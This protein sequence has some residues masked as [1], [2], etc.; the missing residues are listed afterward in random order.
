MSELEVSGKTS[1]GL[2]HTGEADDTHT[3]GDRNSDPPTALTG[4]GPATPWLKGNRR[5]LGAQI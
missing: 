4:F 5:L 2:G 1:T 3:G